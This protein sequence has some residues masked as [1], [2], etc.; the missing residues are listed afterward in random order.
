MCLE[1]MAATGERVILRPP[2]PGDAPAIYEAIES[3]RAE[4]A[5][6]MGWCTPEYALS[7]V[8]GWISS[9]TAAENEHSFT[10]WDVSG[11]HCL[12]SCGLNDINPRHK[13]ANLGYWIRSSH[14]GR[15]LATGATL[16]VADYAF[17][18]LGLV[19]VEIVVALE[20]YASQAVAVKVGAQREGVLR[21][22]LVHG[23]RAL[24]A[25]LFSLIPADLT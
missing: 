9:T 8:E 3:S 10:L 22:G 11:E 18:A 1:F 17:S 5:P 7:A 14:T 24:D 12:G 6:W 2:V 16:Q 19:R 15:G 23:E 20:N 21:N 13:F 25:V 4:I